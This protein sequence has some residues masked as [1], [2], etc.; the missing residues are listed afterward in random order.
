MSNDARQNPVHPGQLLRAMLEERGWA[1]QEL[2]AI[3]GY[4][5]QTISSIVA[6]KS[7]VS[8]DMAI[9]L[10]AA[11][12]ND[13]EQWLQWGAQYELS[14][15]EVDKDL[16]ERRARVFGAAPI[17]D[18][19]KRGWLEETQDVGD[20]EAHLSSFFGQDLDEG[21]VFPIAAKR[22]IRL[23]G[24]NPAEVA[25][26]FRARQLAASL[27]A[28]RFSEGRL[29][30]A[31][32]KLRKLAAYPK[33]VSRV[34]ALLAD[35]GVRFVLVEPLPGAAMD[36]AAFWLDEGSPVIAVSARFDRIDAFWF[37]LMHEWFHIRN[38]DAISAD[39]SLYN[40]SGSGITISVASDKSER[41]A[42]E[43]ATDFLVNTEEMDSFV[44]RLA[45]LF[46]TERIIQFANKVKIHPGI[47]VGQLQHRG[48]IGYSA[49]RNMLVK[50]RNFVART[51]LTDGWGETVD[52]GFDFN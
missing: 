12:G 25:W 3:T 26:C 36:G 27:H 20:L 21:V 6:G 49:H 22:S 1:Q 35:F 9:A 29:A 39:A 42:N 32:K 18:M 43:M 13:P 17:R 51:A 52:L 23:D 44:R 37:T 40:E 2:A 33:E 19:W 41:V 45:P 4:R 24:L 5:R 15:A 14:L 28:E 34:P 10:G 46:P 8:P 16:V 31:E 11:F 50:I 48:E 7:G 38:R 47:I 30:S